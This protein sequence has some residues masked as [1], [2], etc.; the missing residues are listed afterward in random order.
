MTRTSNVYTFFLLC[1][2]KLHEIFLFHFEATDGD[3]MDFKQFFHLAKCC[4]S[5]RLKYYAILIFGRTFK[6]STLKNVVFQ[7]VR[8]I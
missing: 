8:K 1:F 6:K 5:F 7:V 4:R 3:D 2:I